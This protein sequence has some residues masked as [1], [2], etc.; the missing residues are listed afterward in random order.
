METN[1]GAPETLST[2]R[3]L[4]RLP[5]LP[6]AT[7]IFEY[8]SDPTVVQYM[9]YPPRTNLEDLVEHLK[10]HRDRWEADNFSWVLT[11]KPEDKAIGTISCSIEED[12]AEFGYL[13]NRSH[14]GQGYATEASSAIVSWAMARNDISR[15]WAT[16]DPEN[17]A[18]VR[19]LEKCGLT[20]ESLLPNYQVRPNISD[21]PRDALL[22]ALTK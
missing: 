7:A 13:L 19:V 10:T 14:W 21:V 11:V 2:D 22:Y 1:A 18:S 15:V 8:A 16:C 5:R 9:N 3:L 12:R 6:D 4:L 17:L 20:R